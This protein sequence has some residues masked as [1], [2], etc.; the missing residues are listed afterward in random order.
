MFIKNDDLL[1]NNIQK[2]QILVAKTNKDNSQLW[3]PL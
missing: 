2:Y 3:L 1:K